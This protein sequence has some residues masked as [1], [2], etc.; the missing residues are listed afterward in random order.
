MCTFE[1]LYTDGRTVTCEHVK[2]ASYVSDGGIN[3]DEQSL[4]T[5]EFPL[6]RTIW[7]FA[8]TK[9]YCVSNDGLR[10]ITVEAE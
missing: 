5:H 2:K 8:E 1:F 6:D 10:S 7:L 4:T 9:S 3:V